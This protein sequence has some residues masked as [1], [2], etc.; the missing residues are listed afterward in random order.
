MSI[1]KH[2]L[3]FYEVTPVIF[4]VKGL[5]LVIE[6]FS[7]LDYSL[8]H[9]PDV[10]IPLFSQFLVLQNSLDDVA[11]KTRISWIDLSNSRSEKAIHQISIFFTLHGDGKTSNSLS[12]ESEVFGEWLNNH[13]FHFFFGKKLNRIGIFVQISWN[14]SLV[15]HVKNVEE[16]SLF[17]DLQNLSPLFVSRIET[18]WIVP[19]WM[20]NNRWVLRNFS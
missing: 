4:R 1:G 17:G 8:T 12:I 9:G 14:K 10:L 6:K 16:L 11:S 5:N 3:L 7:H 13:D 15:G 18:S 19:H 2:S 20:E